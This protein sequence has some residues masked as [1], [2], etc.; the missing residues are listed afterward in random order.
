MHDL[1]DQL[2]KAIHKMNNFEQLKK[3]IEITVTAEGLRIE[4][5]ESATGTFFDSGSS[6][7]N[8]SGK[9]LL[10]MLALE[11]QKLPNTI[12]IEGHTDCKP[13]AGAS[14]YSNWELSADRANAARRLMQENGVRRNQVSQVRG[15]ADQNLRKKDDPGDPSNRRITILVQYLPKPEPEDEPVKAEPEA[16]AKPTDARPRQGA[17]HLK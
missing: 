6:Q 13:F 2:Q 16:V 9:E 3:Q 7:L 12:S 5:L 11:M 17:A 15:F 8:D 4:L 14:N 10:V 1:K